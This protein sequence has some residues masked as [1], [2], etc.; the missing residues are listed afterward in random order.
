MVGRCLVGHAGVKN[1][2]KCF[3]SLVF[4]IHV[5]CHFNY[6]NYLQLGLIELGI[7]WIELRIG[8]IELG[9]CLIE[10]G[11]CLIELGIGLEIHGS[12]HFIHHNIHLQL[13]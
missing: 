3:K 11:I 5:T 1:C 6:H 7:G 8:L 9:I 10:L 12:Q 13:G 4:I 2:R